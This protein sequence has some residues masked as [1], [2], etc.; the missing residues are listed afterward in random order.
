MGSYEFHRRRGWMLRPATI[1]V[2]LHDT[3]ETHNLS[4]AEIEALPERIHEI[5]C[6]PV[7]ET[8][9]RT[10]GSKGTSEVRA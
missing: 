6:R 5:V 7:D 1:V 4:D 2:H 9:E 8:M 10:E 3:I